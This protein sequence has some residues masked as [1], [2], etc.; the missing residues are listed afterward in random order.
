[1][2][3][4]DAVVDGPV[5]LEAFARRTDWQLATLL[6]ALVVVPGAVDAYG[7]HGAAGSVRATATATAVV[8]AGAGRAAGRPGR[9]GTPVRPPRAC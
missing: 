4:F 2:S 8:D 5:P 9:R 1:M 7:D 3:A 6:V